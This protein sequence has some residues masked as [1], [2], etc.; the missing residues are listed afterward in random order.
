MKRGFEIVTCLVALGGCVPPP[1][2]PGACLAR[3]SLDAL[4]ASRDSVTPDGNAVFDAVVFA[5]QIRVEDLGPECAG[6][7]GKMLQTIQIRLD[8]VEAAPMGGAVLQEFHETVPLTPGECQLGACVVPF[9]FVWNPTPAQA[10]Q[11]PSGLRVRPRCRAELNVLDGTGSEL[12]RLTEAEA[13]GPSVQ[14]S[15]AQTPEEQAYVKAREIEEKQI[16]RHQEHDSATLPDDWPFRYEAAP[17]AVMDT[18]ADALAQA[19]GLDLPAIFD[20]QLARVENDPSVRVK[21]SADQIGAWRSAF[22]ASRGTLAVA[23][24]DRGTP[25]MI[26]GLDPGP[27]SGTPKAAATEYLATTA[28]LLQPLFRMSSTDHLAFQAAFGWKLPGLQ[29]V[30]F[31]RL[32]ALLGQTDPAWNMQS[33]PVAGDQVLVAVRYTGV[34]GQQARVWTAA[35]QWTRDLAAPGPL[36]PRKDI[37]AAAVAASGLPG[38]VVVRVAGPVYVPTAD[39]G[40][41]LHATIFVRAGRSLREV[42]IDAETAAVCYVR[43]GMRRS[44]NRLIANYNPATQDTIVANDSWISGLPFARICPEGASDESACVT[45]DVEGRYD[46]S[47]LGPGA[48]H[49][50]VHLHNPWYREYSL[51][52]D[53]P[54]YTWHP[55]YEALVDATAPVVN[56]VLPDSTPGR[57]DRPFK[58][59]LTRNL[60][61]HLGYQM[62]AYEQF[63]VGLDEVTGARKPRAQFFVDWGPRGTVFPCTGSSFPT[64]AASH[65]FCA[66]CQ[67]GLCASDWYERVSCASDDV[68]AERGGLPTY[69]DFGYGVCDW[70][71]KLGL[72]VTGWGCLNPVA[73]VWGD[74]C[75]QGFDR[76][77]DGTPCGPLDSQ[78]LGNCLA[79]DTGQFL[80]ENIAGCDDGTPFLERMTWSDASALVDATHEGLHH[81]GP[82]LAIGGHI[83][84]AT[85][86]GFLTEGFPEIAWQLLYPAIVLWDN[87]VNIRPLDLR[88]TYI[89][90]PVAGGTES[91]NCRNAGEQ[92]PADSYYCPTRDPFGD[93]TPTCD[94]RRCFTWREDLATHDCCGPANP[95]DCP[96]EVDELQIGHDEL[97]CQHGRPY[98]PVDAHANTGWFQ[99]AMVR[100][101]AM[102]GRGDALAE[103]LSLPFMG[104]YGHVRPELP[105]LIQVATTATDGWDSLYHK[106]MIL[107]SALAGT[108]GSENRAEAWLAL[109]ANVGGDETPTTIDPESGLT[110]HGAFGPT[111]RDL[112]RLGTLDASGTFG[113][114]YDSDTWNAWL[115]AGRSYDVR[116]EVSEPADVAV[117]VTWDEDIPGP[118]VWPCTSA[119]EPHWESL[120]TTAGGFG[121]AT[122]VPS[123]DGVYS[124]RA[125]V[126]RSRPILGEL[127]S[128]TLRVDMGD[129]LPDQPEQAVAVSQDA[130]L[131]GVLEST[132]PS[133]VDV[134]SVYLASSAD[135]VRV[136]AYV[137]AGRREQCQVSV[138]GPDGTVAGTCYGPGSPSGGCDVWIE[139]GSE[140]GRYLI[141]VRR[142]AMTAPP[143]DL[144]YWLWTDAATARPTCNSLTPPADPPSAGGH[145]P[146]GCGLEDGPAY[147]GFVDPGLAGTQA[148]WFYARERQI[149][150]LTVQGA[151]RVGVRNPTVRDWWTSTP[152]RGVSADALLVRPSDDPIPLAFV[153]PVTGWYLVTVLNEAS[154]TVPFQIRFFASHY[155]S[156]DMP[157]VFEATG[158]L[159]I[160]PVPPPPVGPPT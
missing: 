70:G 24:S 47:L 62:W 81:A 41:H 131:A 143:A 36:L 63:G 119:T 42:G 12:R 154:A 66:S 53:A 18:L 13:Q 140:P 74:S 7:D 94:M 14:V 116:M 126:A 102:V 91:T 3:L 50:R 4:T 37:E 120:F 130:M 54:S 20:A 26:W 82:D 44:S 84:S 104:I 67:L 15:T 139:P 35:A 107:G 9:R 115:F 29:T 1:P 105:P 49:A 147:A 61:I 98:T 23:W 28:W 79:L 19:R 124:F 160:E 125:F 60:M 144:S 100:F 43:D 17:V 141:Q 32:V 99:A 46:A 123:E 27:L 59:Y 77:V 97:I 138:K 58:D 40:H 72:S 5:G 117:S 83:D 150:G 73:G 89:G 78:P 34:P 88:Q 92:D 101:S 95:D 129:D 38:G 134:L 159:P 16:G 96:A 137:E 103:V 90:D 122:F 10:G 133:D 11:L 152:G 80:C 85:L 21:P 158:G 112:W 68:C 22:L 33:V 51:E 69:C 48:A 57:A 45:T 93:L 64:E 8:V 30:R 151:V 111:A 121:S 156:C 109:A 118:R 106:L 132:R 148:L 6:T 142:V 52:L 128:Y 76:N 114:I 157:S 75:D 153:A 108:P 145:A 127:V 149:V 65:D 56:L 136:R 110:H 113:W 86:A 55:R 39:A 87:R 135:R 146:A 155:E 2:P 25:E 71:G 31:R